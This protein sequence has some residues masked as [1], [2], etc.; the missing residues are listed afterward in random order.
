MNND[1]LKCPKLG[2]SCD[3][4]NYMDM[5]AHDLLEW[6]KARKDALKISNAALADMSGIPKGTIDRLFHG[7]HIDFKYETIR[8][9]VKALIGG[10]WK[11]STCPLDGAEENKEL[12]ETLRRLEAENSKYRE[13]IMDTGQQ[14]REDLD[15]RKAEEQARVDYLKNQ[16]KWN[17]RAIATLGLLLFVC[18]LVIIGAL[19]VDKMNSD[20]GFFWRAAYDFSR[21]AGAAAFSQV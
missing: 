5:S 1:C 14:H 13:Y 7:E 4:P 15:T 18:L 16:L 9:I 10:E 17:R 3:G 20:I 6:C 12:L 21:D 11:K 19:M 8:P 2:V